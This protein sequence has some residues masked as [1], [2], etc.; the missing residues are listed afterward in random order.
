MIMYGNSKFSKNH[1][2]LILKRN[3][4]VLHKI[5]RKDCSFKKQKNLFQRWNS[6]ICTVSSACDYCSGIQQDLVTD[7][8]LL[9]G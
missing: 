7:L 2:E 5:F 3:P 8:A 4:E 9:N 1:C 6:Y